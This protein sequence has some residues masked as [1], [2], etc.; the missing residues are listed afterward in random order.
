M[1]NLKINSAGSVLLDVYWSGRT[2]GDHVYVNLPPEG[3]A[4]V[5]IVDNFGHK[6]DWT[7]RGG[8]ALENA[9]V[10]NGEGCS[11]WFVYPP[12]NEG[13]TS[14]SFTYEAWRLEITDIPLL[15]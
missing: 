12:L 3:P 13:V 1:L 6:Y 15:E 9:T 8:C 11:G 2:S 7:K 5:Y 4:V 10:K 14:V